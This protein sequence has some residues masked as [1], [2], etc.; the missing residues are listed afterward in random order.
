M[1]N[2]S[3]IWRACVPVFCSTLL[4][5][6][7]HAQNISG[8]VDVQFYPSS[9]NSEFSN[10]TR[11]QLGRVNLPGLT[12]LM[13]NQADPE[14]TR[15][16][17]LDAMQNQDAIR[18]YETRIRLLEENEGMFAQALYEPL[19]SAALLY[20]QQQQ[21]IPALEIFDRAAQISKTANGLYSPDQISLAQHQLKSLKAIHDDQKILGLLERLVLIHQKYYGNDHTETAFALQE[22][23]VW[24]LNN[25]MASLKL[26][27]DTRLVPAL[28]SGELEKQ[29][30]S[31][32]PV[33]ENLYDAQHTFI[34]AI[35]TVVSNQD[36]SDKRLYTL[37]D[38]LISTY[39][40]N[41]NHEQILNNP[42]AYWTASQRDFSSIKRFKT[43]GAL[44]ADFANGEAAY[45]R[46]LKYLERNAQ[47]TLGELSQTSLALADWYQLFGQYDKARAEREKLASTLQRANLSEAEIAELMLAESPVLLPT[48][49]E[50]P[51]SPRDFSTESTQGHI[52]LAIHINAWGKVSDVETLGVSDSTPQPV[53]DE[54][55]SMVKAARFRVDSAEGSNN[56][57]RYYYQYQ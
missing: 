50:T 56:G 51:L 5:C 8:P 12:G 4:L 9:L 3:T 2:R 52:D 33:I 54:L 1:I 24:K 7:A 55:I 44:P 27:P 57:I 35:Q 37:E 29:Y 16:F 42:D 31:Y 19:L 48:F 28:E 45:V 43:L 6:S 32:S 10:A 22:L 34:D 30:T 20:Q 21:H 13:L 36:F 26:H 46:K 38:D 17:Q 47:A 23:G 11:V 18:R 49:L 41:A 40:L 39:Y 53:I 15:Q 14:P 25:F